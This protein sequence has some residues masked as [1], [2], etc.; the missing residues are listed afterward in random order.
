MELLTMSWPLLRRLEA[1][2]RF[3]N[4]SLLQVYVALQLGLDERQVGRLVRFEAHEAASFIPAQRGKPSNGRLNPTR[5][6]TVTPSSMEL[7]AAK[8]MMSS[9][10]A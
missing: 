10:T 6:M 3:V 7:N 2:H 1:V 4:G 8:P 5:S 9:V